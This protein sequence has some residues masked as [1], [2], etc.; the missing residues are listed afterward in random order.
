MSDIVLT[1]DDFC[2]FC[3]ISL[4][5]E[6]ESRGDFATTDH[7]IPRSRNGSGAG[8]YVA[9]CRACNGRKK[10]FSLSL[11]REQHGGGVFWGEMF[12]PGTVN[13]TNLRPKDG[14]AFKR[15]LV[16]RLRDPTDRSWMNGRRTISNLR[17]MTVELERMSPVPRPLA[18]KE[19]GFKVN[20]L[21]RF[22]GVGLRWDRERQKCTFYLPWHTVTV[23][24]FWRA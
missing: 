17:S 16:E 7:V 6:I 5:R 1:V 12:H 24:I 21:P 15:W 20:R 13:H 10:A 11:F 2:W 3:G 19:M 23:G 14:S 4:Q 8:N 22:V 18:H 9:C